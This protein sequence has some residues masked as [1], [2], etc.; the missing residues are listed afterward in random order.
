[1]RYS[2]DWEDSL[3]A[4]PAWQENV[5][6]VRAAHGIRVQAVASRD[7]MPHAMARLPRHRVSLAF[8]PCCLSSVRKTA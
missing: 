5:I 6:L 3:L 4:K 1:M 8:P 7:T 2:V